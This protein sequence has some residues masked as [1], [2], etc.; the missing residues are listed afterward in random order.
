MV[1][2]FTIKDTKNIAFDTIPTRN[3]SFKKSVP[4][5]KKTNKLFERYRVG[6]ESILRTD[7]IYV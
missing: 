5:K 2:S 7:V 6:V 4:G 1:G 3:S